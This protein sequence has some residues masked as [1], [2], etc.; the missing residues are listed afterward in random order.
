[1]T[2]CGEVAVNILKCAGIQP[3]GEQLE[4]FMQAITMELEANRATLGKNSRK[5]G[6]VTAVGFACFVLI[7][8]FPPPPPSRSAPKFSTVLDHF[9]AS[10]RV[11]RDFFMCE[12]SDMATIA[13]SIDDIPLQIKDRYSF[14]I[15]PANAEDALA[16]VYLRGV[17]LTIA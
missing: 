2:S 5:E 9:L 17:R 13:K 4:L 16:M 7:L 1:M 8:F 3:T 11:A 15:A 6:H 10:A 14:C 12:V